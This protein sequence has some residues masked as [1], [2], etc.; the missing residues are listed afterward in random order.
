M[1]VAGPITRMPVDQLDH[2]ARLVVAAAASIPHA[3]SAQ[4]RPRRAG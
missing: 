3:G 2:F 4:S 1:S